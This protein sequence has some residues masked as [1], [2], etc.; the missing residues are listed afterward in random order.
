MKAMQKDNIERVTICTNY[1]YL[2]AIKKEIDDKE[3]EMI[4]VKTENGQ[5]T[6]TINVNNTQNN[7]I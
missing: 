7:L 3:I 6:G 1:G 2:K 4:S 5:F